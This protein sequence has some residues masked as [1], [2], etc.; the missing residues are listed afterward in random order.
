MV[1]GFAARS[2]GVVRL[3]LVAGLAAG[4]T[5]PLSAAKPRDAEPAPAP[6]RGLPDNLI[7]PVSMERLKLGE[8]L[9]LAGKTQDATDQFEAALAADPRNRRAYIGLAR[10]A[11]AEGLPGKAV[12]FYR[13]ALEIDPNDLAALELQGMALVERGAK[14][15]A[16]SNLERVKKLCDGPCPQADRLSAAIARGPKTQTA[17]TAALDKQQ[18]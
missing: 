14:A 10:A 8:S 6:A 17:Q 3:V 1:E 7:A 5:A 4:L 12:R 2:L 16:E 11:E 15:R 18:D 13:E 9:L